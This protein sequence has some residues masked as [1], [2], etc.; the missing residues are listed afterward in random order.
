MILT[1][2]LSISYEYNFPKTD[3]R[4]QTIWCMQNTTHAS[5]YMWDCDFYLC[6]ILVQP[7]HDL[8]IYT[9]YHVDCYALSKR[10]TEMYL[11]SSNQHK[12]LTS[13][14]FKYFYLHLSLLSAQMY[15]VTAK[16]CYMPVSLRKKS[17]RMNTPDKLMCQDMT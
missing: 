6:Y 9:F 16:P 8:Y 2:I 5:F 1:S 12:V 11:I 10:E 4:G 7:D 17:I 14:K 3:G 13:L 15:V